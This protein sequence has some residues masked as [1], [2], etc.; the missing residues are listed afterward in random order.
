VEIVLVAHI[1]TIDGPAVFVAGSIVVLVHGHISVERIGITNTIATVVI[2]IG[3]NAT[4]PIAGAET[5][6]G[7]TK[8]YSGVT[9]V[10]GIE[11]FNTN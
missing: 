3:C 7:F 11:C 9:I 4:L 8:A 5:T 2:I 6:D 10:T 1:S